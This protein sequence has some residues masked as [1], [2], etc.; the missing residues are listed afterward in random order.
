[1]AQNPVRRDTNKKMM[2]VALKESLGVVMPACEI[3]G[4]SR[5]THYIWMK[6]DPEYR[7][8][9]E[10]CR[11]MAIDFAESALHKQIKGGGVPSTIF[12]LKTIGKDRGYVERQEL[13]VDGGLSLEVQF[14]E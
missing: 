10:E 7:R 1:M 3:T 5:T 14:I 11:E 4:T 12:Y 13:D 6:E 2:L 9:V 8:A